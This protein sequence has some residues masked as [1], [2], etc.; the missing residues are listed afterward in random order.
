[1]SGVEYLL[2]VIEAWP[3]LSPELRIA[4]LAVTRMAKVRH[5]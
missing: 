1:M 5:K 2:E 3:R 4:V